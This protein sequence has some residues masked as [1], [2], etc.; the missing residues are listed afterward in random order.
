VRPR[1]VEIETGAGVRSYPSATREE[2]PALVAELIEQGEDVYQVRLLSSSLEDA[3][4]EAVGGPAQPARE[5][6]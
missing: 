6:T 1:G 4:L 3:Y 2:V 5:L